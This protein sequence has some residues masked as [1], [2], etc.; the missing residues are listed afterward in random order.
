MINKVTLIGRVG[1]DPKVFE[2]KTKCVTF[3]V[4]TDNG[5]GDNKSTDWHSIKCFD[6]LAETCEKHLTKGQLVYIEGRISYNERNEVKYTDIVA[7]TVKFL[8][9][10][11]EA[12]PEEKPAPRKRETKPADTNDIPY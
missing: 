11:A 12:S 6:K 9:P 10:R 4:A 8:S 5:Y 7:Y 2:G 1:Q 3:S